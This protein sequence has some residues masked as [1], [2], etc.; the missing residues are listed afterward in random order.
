MIV[1]NMEA[2]GCRKIDSFSDGINVLVMN[3]N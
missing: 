1:H 3:L 2:F